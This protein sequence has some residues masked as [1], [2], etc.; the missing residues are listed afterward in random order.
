VLYTSLDPATTVV[1]V[2]VQKGFHVLD[3]PLNASR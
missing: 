1:E 2:A 3:T